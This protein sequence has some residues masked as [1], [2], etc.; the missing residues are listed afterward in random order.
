LVF[1]SDG[2][3]LFPKMGDMGLLGVTVPEEYGGLGLGYLE[4]TIAMEEISRASASVGLSY[5][6]HSNL[7]V[8]QLRRNGTEEQKRNYLPKLLSG[9]HVGSLAMSEPNAGSDVVSMR[10][11]AELAP[12]GDKYVMNGSKAWITNSPIASTFLIY[13]KS[14][15]DAKPSK[16]ITAFIVEKGWK[17][18][19]VGPSLDKFGVSKRYAER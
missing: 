1:V 9:E 6:A 13:A 3:D 18:F 8:N 15:K 11:R 14:E 4:H 7:M 12:S 16:S 2:Q 19:E 17:G 10:T 5:G